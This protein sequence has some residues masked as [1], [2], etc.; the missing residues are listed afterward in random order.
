M[1]PQLIGQRPT[2]V[3]RISPYHTR[4][5]GHSLHFTKNPITKLQ[6]FFG[7]EC[8]AKFWGRLLRENRQFLRFTGQKDKRQTAENQYVFSAVCLGN[9]SPAQ[10]KVFQEILHKTLITNFISINLIILISYFN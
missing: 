1:S 7:G 3:Q 5:S 6:A 8:W 9:F 4:L 10:Q 2:Y